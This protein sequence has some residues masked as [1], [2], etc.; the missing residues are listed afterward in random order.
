MSTRSKTVLA[1]L[2]SGG[3]N[4]VRILGGIQDVALSRHWA[5]SSAE[6]RDGGN[7]ALRILRS[8]DGG[9]VGEMLAKIN[10][11]GVIVRGGCLLRAAGGCRAFPLRLP[12]LR[13]PH[14]S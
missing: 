7:G 10:P 14:L 1:F 4:E 2:P 5:F 8:P 13:I 3:E 12:R 9:T 11:D 6:C